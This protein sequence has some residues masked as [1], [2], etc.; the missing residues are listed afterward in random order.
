MIMAL[1]I[2][3]RL[4]HGQVVVSWCKALNITS[5]VV[6][7]DEAANDNIVS[8]A[9][10]MAAPHNIKVAIKEVESAIELLK[11]PRC[12]PLRILVIVKNPEDALKIIKEVDE[13]PYVNV[14]NFGQFSDEHKEER[15][16][17]STS[18]SVTNDELNDFKEIVRL[19]PESTYQ[20]VA[21]TNPV[22]L[23]DLIK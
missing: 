22:A 20:M 13:V 16:S 17:L 21:V 5:I 18:F 4:I 1:R 12:G 2:D 9:L 14:G 19:K 3:E 23:K 15:I 8:M 11:D 7:N 6:A 10:K